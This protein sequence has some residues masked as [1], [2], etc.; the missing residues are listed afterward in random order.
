MEASRIFRVGLTGGIASG[1]TTVA[2]MLAELGAGVVDT[3]DIA[4]EV[5]EPGEAGLKSIEREFGSDVLLETGELD[6]VTMRKLVFQD[7]DARS[8]LEAILHPLIRE[9]TLAKADELDSPYAVIVVP[10]LVETDFDKIVDH[11]VVVDCP[12]ETQVERLM[13][14]DGIDEAAAEAML[15]AQ[16]DR[17]LRNAKADDL[18]DNSVARSAVREQARGLHERLLELALEAGSGA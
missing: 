8:R 5:V 10:L 7:A 4:R 18:I 1:K 3:D 15:A 14:R 17:A 16:T 12:R 6:R 13:Q 11:V 9:R 2:E